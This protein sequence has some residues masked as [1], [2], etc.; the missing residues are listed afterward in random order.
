MHSEIETM[1]FMSYRIALGVSEFDAGKGRVK[2][3]SWPVNHLPCL[4]TSIFMFIVLNH[5]LNELR[6]WIS[7]A[8]RH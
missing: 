4:A 2:G 6:I 5:F 7:I 1:D 8:S 3:M